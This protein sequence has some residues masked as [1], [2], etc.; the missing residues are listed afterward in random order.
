LIALAAALAMAGPA[1]AQRLPVLGGLPSLPVPGV[2]QIT[3]DVRGTLDGA[4]RGLDNDVSALADLRLARMRDLVRANPKALEFDAHGAPVVRGEVMAI[5]PSSGA[6]E[7]AVK[8]GFAVL[9]RTPLEPLGLEVVVLSPPDGA[10]AREGLRRLRKLDP[11]G[12]Y[13]L[14]HI[15]SESG[16]SVSPPNPSSAR[17]GG[18]EVK[19][20]VG[21]IDTG[22]AA[23]HP[24]F[25]GDRITQKG[26]APG[27]VKAAAHGSAVASLMVGRTGGF[28][29]AAPGARLYVADVYGDGPTGGSADAIVHALAWMAQEQVPVV[30]VSLVGPA[31][32]TVAATVRAL[33]ARGVLIVA[34]VGNDGPAAPPLYPASYPGVIA[35][36]AVDARGRI[37]LE[38]GHAAHIDFAAPGADILAAGPKGDLVKVRGTSFAAPIVSGRLAQLIAS[39][40]QAGASRAVAELAQAA[41][42]LRGPGGLGH[43]VIGDDLVT[44]L[45]GPGQ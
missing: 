21:M 11:S 8:A 38:A 31:D 36:T 24:A 44:A 9:R 22:V 43:G 14:D 40:S 16:Q 1:A 15:Y 20:S 45:R 33:I 13:D 7:G 37:L 2:G 18:P 17:S 19:A 32:V 41:R 25:A 42:P 12:Q 28:H 39:P 26:F 3:G 35:V 10:A 6:I 23:D 27:G 5:D 34:P 29:G 30:N 4:T